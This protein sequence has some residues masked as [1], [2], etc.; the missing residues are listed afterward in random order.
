M[1]LHCDC[2]MVHP[3]NPD[4]L[5]GAVKRY[6]RFHHQGF[7]GG[8]CPACRDATNTLAL[9]DMRG[10]LHDLLGQFSELTVYLKAIVKPE[11]VLKDI[12]PSSEEE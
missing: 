3:T 7:H 2:G 4:K 11:I 12:V 5:V 10:L 6:C 1:T 9:E 8:I